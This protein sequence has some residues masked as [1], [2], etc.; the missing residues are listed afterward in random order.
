MPAPDASRDVAISHGV[1]TVSADKS[2]VFRDVACVL[3][4]GERF[5]SLTSTPSGPGR[6]LTGNAERWVAGVGGAAQ[7]DTYPG[8]IAQAGLGMRCAGTTLP[9]SSFPG[10]QS[11]PRASTAPR[12]SLG[13]PSTPTHAPWPP[14]TDALRAPTHRCFACYLAVSSAEGNCSPALLQWSG[15]WRDFGV[16]RSLFPRVEAGEIIAGVRSPVVV[17]GAGAAGLAVSR[18]L[19]DAGLDHLVL[20]RHDVG[21]TWQTQRWDSFR[22]NTPGWMNATLGTVAPTSFSYRDEVVQLLGQRAASLP[23]RTHTPVVEIDSSGS[24]FLVRTPQEQIHA[25]AVVLANGFLNVRRVPSQAS[26][27]APRLLQL[28]TGDYRNASHLPEG[29][30]LIVGG[31]QSGCQIAEDLALA[32]RRV[33]LSTSRVGRWPWIYRGRELM[34]WLVDCG[35]WDQRPQDLAD[36][37]ETRA[38]TPVVAS[39]GRSLSLPMLA[40]LGVSLLGRL[41]SVH[42]EK[43]TFEG[44]PA[45]NIQFADQVARRLTAMADDFIAR[46]AIAAPEPEADLGAGPLEHSTTPELDLATAGI[47]T[48]IWCTGFTTDLSWVRLPILDDTGRPR[49]NRCSTPVPGLWLVGLPWLTRRRSG[50]LY[51]LPDDAAEVVLGISQH[52]S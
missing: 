34:G 29:A 18:A 12:A 1:I 9:T 26:L 7:T 28:H 4:C 46:H 51:G 15:T 25:S 50:I 30:V 36:L 32:G 38:A 39:G 11:A 17:V 23:V 3:V 20:E 8:A 44:S 5:A 14:D 22:L 49:T 52:L 35:F 24:R 33:Y 45:E 47:S 6:S 31:G 41:G 48:V 13:S 10:Q 2:S 43:M 42:G 37:A 19:V 16:V 27:L 21:N 40:R